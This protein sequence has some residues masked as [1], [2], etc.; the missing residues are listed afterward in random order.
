MGDDVTQNYFVFQGLYKY[1]E[2]ADSGPK[3]SISSW[4]SKRL[5]NGKISSVTGFGYPSLV[6][7]N[8][9][10]GVKFYGSILKQNNIRCGSIVNIYIIYRLIPNTNNSNIVLQNCLFDEIKTENTTNP[11]PDKYEYSHWGIGFDSKG[12]YTHPDGCYG[13]MFSFLELM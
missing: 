5:S 11:D 9:R 13:K 7:D 1:F 8:A 2:R 3:K 4:M 10:I 6:L 12:S